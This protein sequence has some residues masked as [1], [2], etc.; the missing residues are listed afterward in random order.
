MAGCRNQVG[1]GSPR[2]L[3]CGQDVSLPLRAERGRWRPA[4]NRDSAEKSISCAH[5]SNQSSLAARKKRDGRS[6]VA[7]CILLLLLGVWPAGV[8]ALRQ[9]PSRQ[10]C[11]FRILAQRS[12]ALVVFCFFSSCRKVCF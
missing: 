6:N 2:F 9:V 1:L 4:E 11:R 7:D 3:T 10:H 12:R 8:L 5:R